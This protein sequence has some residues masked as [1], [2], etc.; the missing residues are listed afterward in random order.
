M[1]LAF[2]ILVLLGFGLQVEKASAQYSRVRVLAQ[3]HLKGSK[4]AILLPVTFRDKEYTFLLDS[5]CAVTVFDDSFRRDLGQLKRKTQVVVPRSTFAV[6]VYDAPQAT[7][8]P[9]DLSRCREVLC[10]DVDVVGNVAGEKLDGL[11][12]MN[13]LRDYVVHVDFDAEM[14][15]FVAPANNEQL[16]WGKAVAIDYDR[17]G[18]PHIDAAVFFDIAADFLVD[19]GA[20]STGS[21]DEQVFQ[22]VL[23]EK[24]AETI[25]ITLLTAGGAIQEREARIVNLLVGPFEYRDLIFAE[26]DSSIL[27][28]SFLS[29]HE[30]IFDF[31][32]KKMY[33]REARD[34]RR[35]DERD[36]SGLHL[37]WQQSKVVVESVQKGGPAHRAGIQAGDVVETI[38]NRRAIQY[39]VWALQ[40]FLRQRDGKEITVTIERDGRSREVSFKL[41]KIL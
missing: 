10:T 3:F 27:G 2:Y 37:A 36:M 15:S 17:A 38:D 26:S 13:F 40:E 19:T 12:G 4:E 28:L 9:L 39:R 24:K 20:L 7:I 33:L 32:N 35:R 8:G 22:K 18:L 30:V 31:P 21:L 1:R 41:E 25:D 6:E 14:I 23:S 34:F 16:R 29:R 5:G 11:I